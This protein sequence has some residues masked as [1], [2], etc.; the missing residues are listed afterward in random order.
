M[1]PL[2][3]PS[4]IE[5]WVN[6]QNTQETYRF[7]LCESAIAQA[8]AQEAHLRWEEECLPMSRLRV[9]SEAEVTAIYGYDAENPSA[10]AATTS[11]ELSPVS[12]M[13]ASM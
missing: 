6:R 5:K 11:R 4:G 13:L 1:V 12:D 2:P 9:S 3:V 8:I 10:I 7:P